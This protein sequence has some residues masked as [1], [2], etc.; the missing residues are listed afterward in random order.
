M[1]GPAIPAGI[2]SGNFDMP[3]FSGAA[4]FG[5]TPAIA[6]GQG[7][8][9][10][11]AGLA[12]PANSTAAKDE[13]LQPE[14]ERVERL[15]AAEPKAAVQEEAAPLP[16]EAM[17]GYCAVTVI[18]QRRWERGNPE[19]GVIHLG[20]LYLFTD[21]AAKK[22]FQDSPE[23]YTPVLNGIDVV[24]FFDQREVVQG[25]REWGFTDPVYDRMFLFADEASMNHFYLNFE[26][27]T[28]PAID[29]MKRAAAEANP[30]R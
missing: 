2:G 19:F 27:Y 4:S 5:G 26:Q 25:S 17:E 10:S 15:P 23:R 7:P 6:V 29:L 14:Q 9:S 8:R 3:S 20:Q 12:P 24:K 13:A 30:R 28:K 21:G 11:F 16:P 1:G 22:K 18:D